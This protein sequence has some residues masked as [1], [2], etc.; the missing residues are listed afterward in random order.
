[1]KIVV[2]RMASHTHFSDLKNL[3]KMN[4]KIPEYAREYKRDYQFIRGINK[5]FKYLIDFMDNITTREL[6]LNHKVDRLKYFIKRFLKAQK[7]GKLK[8]IKRLFFWKYD[9]LNLIEFYENI[10][11][12]I[13]EIKYADYFYDLFCKFYSKIN[14]KYYDYDGNVQVKEC[15]NNEYEIDESDGLLYNDL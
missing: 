7:S 9:I 13:L 4:N 6:F 1:M 11:F 5:E 10:T 15:D 12:D 14:Y 2:S 8:E 3:I